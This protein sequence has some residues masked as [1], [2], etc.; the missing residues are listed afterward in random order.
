VRTV[1]SQ[2][3]AQALQGHIVGQDLPAHDLKAATADWAVRAQLHLLVDWNPQL[4][5]R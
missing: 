3:G 2:L 1:H 5:A 4:F